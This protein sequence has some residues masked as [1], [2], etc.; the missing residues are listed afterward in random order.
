MKTKRAPNGA[1]IIFKRGERM[2]I[3]CY[4]S[5]GNVLKRLYQWDC[6]Q[7]I[8]ISGVPTSPIPDVH[9][10]NRLSKEAMVI[11][12]TISSG[13]VAV[14]VPNVLLTQAEPIIAFIYTAAGTNGHKTTYA[15]HIPVLP[16]PI[17]DD[18]EYEGNIEYTNWVTLASE[19]QALFAQLQDSAETATEKA[20]DA[21][22]AA[23]AAADAANAAAEAVSFDEVDGLVF[24][25]EDDDVYVL[26]QFR[27]KDGHPAMRCRQI[28]ENFEII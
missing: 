7:T 1:F 26:C 19:A 14:K 10:C 12:A 4:D 5:D 13:N 28:N 25:D 17:P 2:S 16:R 24:E 18:Y 20:N 23:N 15:I 21:A 6:N 27:F 9:F 11:D 8:Y 22:D 3:V